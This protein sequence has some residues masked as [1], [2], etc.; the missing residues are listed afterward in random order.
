MKYHKKRQKAKTNLEHQAEV[1]SL[2]NKKLTNLLFKSPK[3]DIR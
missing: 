3:K 1:F 2:I